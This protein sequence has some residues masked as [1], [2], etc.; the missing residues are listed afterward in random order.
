M[1]QEYNG[2]LY[3]FGGFSDT[4]TCCNDLY[5]LDPSRG[6][7]WVKLTT[8]GDVPRQV[9]LHSVVAAKDRL[10]VFGGNSHKSTVHNDLH[11]FNFATNAWT[12]IMPSNLQTLP[13]DR[14]GHTA[15]ATASKMIIV[16]G[17][18]SNSSYLRDT[19]E[20]TFATETWR[21]LGDA[22][23][24]T[25][26]HALFVFDEEV[27]MYGGFTGAVYMD[28]IYK[29]VDD[30]WVECRVSGPS[31]DGR[32]GAATAVHGR[33]LYVFGGFSQR[34]RH[35]DE[36]LR[37]D[38]TTMSWEYLTSLNMPL[39]RAYLQGAMCRGSFYIL[40]GFNGKS[41]VS[42]CRRVRIPHKDWS[43]LPSAKDVPD[44]VDMAVSRFSR[45]R[46][47]WMNRLEVAEFVR[48]LAADAGGN[49]L[50]KVTG[51]TT[52]GSAGPEE[53]EEQDVYPFP[54]PPLDG[55]VGMGFGKQHIL[56]VL[57]K[58]HAARKSYTVDTLVNE[59]MDTPIKPNYHVRPLPKPPK[60]EAKSPAS[61]SA[62][63][64][65]GGT[66]TGGNEKATAELQAKFDDLSSKLE[67]TVNCGVCMENRRNTAFVP[68]G[69]ILCD[70]CAGQTR[71]ECPYCRKPATS[72]IRVHV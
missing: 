15:V 20:F 19:Y 41:C 46:T 10:W 58:L 57:E 66:G 44:L 21:R 39:R 38:L 65:V 12:K 51:T 13:A 56:Q 30:K 36:F 61:P 59:L 53:V 6:N 43:Q 70:E 54:V 71:K 18:K 27:Y 63:S 62:T 72:V 11:S 1:Q 7:S 60:E 40:G 64:P 31:P 26:Y 17:R 67:E 35:L 2:C 23:T 9:Y 22:P 55:L 37:L 29:L 49:L 45:T 68:C 25:A 69:H 34:D 32:C 4:S 28:K 3:L 8:T 42:D 50:N 24:D 52:G 16:G 47:G 33:Y 5:C 48:A 14:H